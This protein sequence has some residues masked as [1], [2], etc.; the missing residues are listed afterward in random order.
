MIPFVR[1]ADGVHLGLSSGER[2]LLTS[3][4]EQ[5][6]QVL[7]G[8]LSADPVTERMFPDA[9]PGDDDASAE[10]RKYTKS[11]LLTQKTTNA[12]IVHDWLTGARDG[13]LDVEDEQAW[14][15]T[16]TDLRLTIADRLGIEDADDEE[17]SVE[18]D[19]GVGLRDVYDWLGYVQEHLVVTLTSR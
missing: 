8:D 6:R 11:D 16:L 4:T 15:R 12:G 9:Y 18:A 14:L 3:L 19:A 2:D 13:S 17:R 5:L 10:F 7:D 1:R